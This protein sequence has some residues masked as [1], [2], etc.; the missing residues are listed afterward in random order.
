MP[1]LAAYTFADMVRGHDPLG[2]PVFDV[3]ELLGSSS[4]RVVREVAVLVPKI[5]RGDLD[6]LATIVT[7]ATRK[8]G[9]GRGLRRAVASTLQTVPVAVLNER[10]DDVLAG[11]WNARLLIRMSHP[12]T[13]DPGRIACYRTAMR[14]QDMVN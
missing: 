4:G 1:L 11:G 9:W 12:R 8:R 14:G 2:L 5:A 7:V 13:R 3:A 10:M 6:A